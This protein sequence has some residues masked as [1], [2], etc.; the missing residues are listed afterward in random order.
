MLNVTVNG[1]SAHVSEAGDGEPVV[2]L[3]SGAGES[4]DW[5]R[6][7][8]E[9]PAGYRSAAL[10]FY[11]CGR[12]PEWPGPTAFTID[13]QAGLVAAVARAV[14]RPVHL[15][16]HS[17]GGAIALRLAVTHPELVRTLT[18][19]EPQCYSLLRAGD[20]PLFEQ[21]ESR[22]RRFCEGYE[23]GEPEP[24]WRMFIDYYSGDGFWDR[25]RPEI[26]AGLLAASPI[27][28][29]SVLF[30][31]PTTVDD[32]RRLQ[33]PTLVMCSEHTTAPEARMCDIIGESSPY[34]VLELLP[35][36]AGHMAPITHAKDVASRVVQHFS[37]ASTG[38]N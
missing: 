29:W 8:A 3:H 31:D 33:A 34:A 22:F 35:S 36:S 16:G 17:Y 27:K 11:G 9:L 38:S 28:R 18:V 19:I 21:H 2:L 20:R 4:R 30:S 37:S 25:L 1:I 6:F 13:D 10:D 5:R 12:T 14:G 7:Q 32:V 23:R 15:C 26:R 24:G